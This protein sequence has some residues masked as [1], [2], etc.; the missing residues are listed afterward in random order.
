MVII[1]EIMNISIKPETPITKSWILRM[2]LYNVYGNRKLACPICH[3]S[4]IGIHSTHA[5]FGA[6][7]PSTRKR[8]I[9]DS[10]NCKQSFKLKNNSALQYTWALSVGSETV[11]AETREW[12]PR[13]LFSESAVT[14]TRHKTVS[15]ETLLLFK[16][17]YLLFKMFCSWNGA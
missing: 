11:S 3:Q 13:Q 9:D 4:Y 17:G 15:S 14:E 8:R 1:Y 6:T 5:Q 10:E 12:A 16:L 7:S 2:S